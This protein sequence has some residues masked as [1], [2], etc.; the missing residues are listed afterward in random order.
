MPMGLMFHY[1]CHNFFF[2]V[3]SPH[4]KASGT[5]IEKDIEGDTSGDFKRLLVAASQV[6]Y[7]KCFTE[8]PPESLGLNL[9]FV[10]SI[11]VHL[12]YYIYL[13]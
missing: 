2:I 6:C 11:V 4:K 5:L 13:C 8:L 1:T 9:S 7:D 12:E 10:S 3:A